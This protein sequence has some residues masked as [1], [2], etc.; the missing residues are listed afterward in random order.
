LHLDKLPRA[1]VISPRSRPARRST[2]P[3][4]VAIAPGVYGVALKM[5]YDTDLANR[6][7][8]Q[9]ADEE[10]VTEKGAKAKREL[11]AWL[12]RGVAFARTLPAKG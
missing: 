7:R 1:R 2:V 4:S 8:E 10:G 11:S 5:A 3:G 12:R 9:L 6:L